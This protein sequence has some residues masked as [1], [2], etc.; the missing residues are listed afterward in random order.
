MW[1]AQN[2]PAYPYR[3]ML[4]VLIAPYK[5][6]A[7]LSMW[8][9]LEARENIILRCR[10][11]AVRDRGRGKHRGFA[12]HE[13]A[14]LLWCRLRKRAVGRHLGCVRPHRLLLCGELGIVD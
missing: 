2:M 1:A 9:W 12:P 14:Q 10:V 8:R 4:A 7:L 5:A 13:F 3:G 6:I 11:G